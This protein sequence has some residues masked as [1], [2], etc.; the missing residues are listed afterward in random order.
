MAVP[1]ALRDNVRSLRL[2]GDKSER[3]RKPYGIRIGSN[4]VDITRQKVSDNDKPLFPDLGR[5]I[6]GMSCAKGDAYTGSFPCFREMFI[7]LAGAR[8]LPRFCFARHLDHR[9]QAGGSQSGHA[10]Q[11]NLQALSQGKQSL[12]EARCANKYAPTERPR[13]EMQE[14]RDSW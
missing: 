10:R 7:R 3:V 1:P 11:A 13:T 2:L 14:G 8:R 5:R 12:L 6:G 9:R 4:H